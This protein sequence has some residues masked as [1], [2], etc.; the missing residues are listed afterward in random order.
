ME[1]AVAGALYTAENILEGALAFA[2]GIAHPT[3]PLKANLAHITSVPL[4]RCHHT[5]SVVKGRAYIFGGE[6]S[7]GTLA[8]NAMH[9]VIL[10]SSGVLEADYTSTP[11]RPALAGDVPAPRK[12]HSAVVIGDSI[13]IFGGEGVASEDG[14]VWVFTTVSNSWSFLDPSPGT[15]YPSHRAF[16]AAVSSELPGPKDEVVY[17]E[18]APQQPADPAKVVPEPADSDSWGTI[19]VVG[20]RNTENN[21]LLND[22]F[23]FDIRTR[24][25]S[26]VPTPLGQP[27]EGAS[28]ALVQ[29]R[30]YRFGGKGVET[31]TSGSMEFVNISPVWKHAEGG[32]TPLTSGWAWEELSHA[33]GD[34][35]QA[36]SGAG[37]SSVTTGQGRQYLLV[38][39]GEGERSTFFDDIW[40]FRLP[41]ER[42]TAVSL[43]DTMRAMIKKDMNEATWA[44]VQYKY[45]DSTG[46]EEKEV[47]GEPKRMGVRGCF[48]VARG[49]EVDGASVVAWGG[50]DGSGKVLGDGWLVTIER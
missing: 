4:P 24:T 28:L 2:K 21:E 44:E 39:G 31:F 45:V 34:A 22:G 15:L 36:R 12:G 16:H 43:K 3:L 38:L 33:E 50:I 13:Y 30:L 40:A 7:P 19:F 46:E 11:A 25:W 48:A 6:S 1:P 32:I 27:R 18:K 29:N 26:N 35:P 41:P 37:L 9:I 10:P 47:P 42:A 14:R 23:A 20:G 49:T 5:L 17:K 8:D